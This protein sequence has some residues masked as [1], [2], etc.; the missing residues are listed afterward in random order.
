MNAI[1]WI[2]E[3]LFD[4]WKIA[5]CLV[6]AS[7][8]WFDT[9]AGPGTAAVVG[10]WRFDEASGD[11]LDSSGNGN[12]GTWEGPNTSQ[13]ASKPG[14]GNAAEFIND[15]ENS[16][17][18]QVPG[19][20]SLMIGAN[21][22]DPWSFT[23]WAHEYGSD[24]PNQPF[25]AEYGTMLHY[26]KTISDEVPYGSPVYGLSIQSGAHYDPQ[27]WLWTH[28]NPDP[29]P[30][31]LGTGVDPTPNLDTWTHV[32]YVYN[33]SDFILYL[34]GSQ[35][36]RATV[37][38]ADL[39]YE[40]YNGTLQIG[41]APGFG[42]SRNYH[43]I[44]DD[45]AIFNE[46]LSPA[47][48]ALV[49]AGDFTS[50]IEPLPQPPLAQWQTSTFG[51]WNESANWD[52]LVAPNSTNITTVF[53][54][55]TTT[56]TTVVNDQAVTVKGIQ[57]HHTL[58]YII[59]GAGSVTLDTNGAGN[60][61]VSV[62]NA[63]SGVIHEMQLPV[64]LASDTDLDVAADTGLE[65]DHRLEL[66]G[67]RL[68][69]T[70]AGAVHVNNRGATGTSGV[71]NNS[72][73]VGGVG[74][75]TGDFINTSTGTLIVDISGTG[76]YDCQGLTV[77]GNASLAGTL[78][79]VLRDG[80]TPADGDMFHVLT[81][82]S[83]TEN[84]LVLGGDS[85]N[86]SYAISNHRL[87]LTYGTAS[88]TGD[89]DLD[90][91]VDGAD[92]LRWQQGLGTIYDS[93][94][95][96]AWQANFGTVP[97]NAIALAVP[98][99]ASWLLLLAIAGLG[100][101]RLRRRTIGIYSAVAVLICCLGTSARATVLI[102]SGEYGGNGSMPG[103]YAPYEDGN[104]LVDEY[105]DRVISTTQNHIASDDFGGTD[106]YN[107]FYRNDGEGFTPNVVVDYPA[108]STG[109]WPA[110]RYWS[111]YGGFTDAIYPNSGENGTSLD[112]W[113]MTFSA[114][115]GVQVRIN[116][117][118]VSRAGDFANSLT[119]NVYEGSDPLNPGNLL[120]TSGSTLVNP[121]TPVTFSP[122]VSENIVSIVY[123]FEDYDPLWDWTIDNVKFSQIGGGLPSG[124]EWNVD[125]S[126]VWTLPSNWTPDFTPA[127]I[128]NGN[129]KTAV[130]GS[131]TT[132][133]ST[134]VLDDAITVKKI[135]LNH[136]VPYYLAGSGELT[137]EA[138]A[139]NATVEVLNAG[140][141]VT[142]QIV[143]RTSL[144]SNTDVVL[145][146]GTALEM[147]NRVR[148]HGFNLV[149][150]GDGTL[151]INNVVVA[152]GGTVTGLT[153]TIAGS[154]SIAGDFENVGAT[155]A[156]G[157]SPGTLTILGE[158]RQAPEGKLRIELGGDQRGTE[159]DVLNVGGTA[160]LGGTLEVVL[161]DGFI[162]AEGAVFDILDFSDSSGDFAKLDLPAGFLWDTSGLA[163][164]G[165]LC[166]VRAIPEPSAW[167]LGTLVF[168]LGIIRRI[169]A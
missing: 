84:G 89:F 68:N 144:G 48:L 1:H 40:G 116:S 34:N 140:G 43:G 153:G 109:V 97:P 45:V 149:K 64:I 54:G 26:R 169:R 11:A 25:G 110:F 157:N 7:Y 94:D 17:S 113:G 33:G 128:P 142:H 107:F 152:D 139:G 6:L 3:R 4:N 67:N 137:L 53:G 105:G 16:S 167:I 66:N 82:G 132:N 46:A 30:F 136:T 56:P 22:G 55:Q 99:P 78:S 74:T 112:M 133:P 41:A 159:Y 51:K 158:Y 164:H 93:S 86:F 10:L 72:G 162:P 44:L 88:L 9:A 57:F 5:L 123:L 165:T 92:F 146:T 18:I 42:V 31:K 161:F 52:P 20:F 28:P 111:S 81:A 119:V 115:P 100:R 104:T 131:V 160:T 59:A 151:R 39:T 138:D 96:T 29:H 83:M 73:N 80:Y 98:E 70:G 156:P 134:V 13:V 101:M 87:V 21:P 77:T 127:L 49:M 120:W 62:L 118:Q 114:D 145:A 103:T 8:L 24:G 148:L 60:A 36:F 124:A 37:G 147:N 63:G 155:M 65:F 27:Y 2:N 38:A 15:G 14:F 69:V 129:D 102:F 143:A 79:I 50:F 150:S 117:L 47:D 126:G 76:T 95:L 23:T 108:S 122:N 71:L 130:F 141:D 163:I 91:D 90:G 35:A 166:V 125:G 58:P 61:S 85:E 121:K 19:N 106:W 75:I 135:Q 168:V 12:H 32:A 154:G